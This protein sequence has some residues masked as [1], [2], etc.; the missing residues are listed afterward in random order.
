MPR[1]SAMSCMLMI[2]IATRPWTGQRTRKVLLSAVPPN[3]FSQHNSLLGVIRRWREVLECCRVGL[4]V[5]RV[6]G[7]RLFSFVGWGGEAGFI[8]RQLH[9]SCLC[10]SAIAVVQRLS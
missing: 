6:R 10:C 7:W 9:V 3:C 4:M 2:L 1:M 5:L 8:S